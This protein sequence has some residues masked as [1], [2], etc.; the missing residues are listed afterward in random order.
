MVQELYTR[1]GMQD[2]YPP[3]YAGRIPSMVYP[4]IYTTCTPWVYLPPWYTPYLHTLGIPSHPAT[5][6]CRGVHCVRW[7]AVTLWA[8]DGR[9]AWVRASF[10]PS[11]PK[12]VKEGGSFCAELFRS[13]REEERKDWIEQGEPSSIPLVGD[14]SAHS[15]HPINTGLAL[16]HHPFHCWI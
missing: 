10:S 8:Q 6:C 1:H 11:F 2:G 13:P 16:R 3:W 14:T 15:A 7:P 12:G 5:R 9:I 4:G